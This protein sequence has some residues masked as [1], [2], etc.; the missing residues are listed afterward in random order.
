MV[1]G[2]YVSAIGFEAQLPNLLPESTRTDISVF[3]DTANVWHVDYSD[4]VDDTDKIRTSVGIAANI[5]TTI[6]PLSFIIAQDLT[7]ANS[8]ATETFNFRIGTSF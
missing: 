5:F 2:N 6:G 1:G 4:T 7:K 8:D 3:F